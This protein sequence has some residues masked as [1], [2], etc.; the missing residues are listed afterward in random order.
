ML[1]REVLA[2]FLDIDDEGMG[3]RV[4]GNS[5][6]RGRSCV[7]IEGLSTAERLK[8]FS[9][10]S[11]QRHFGQWKHQGYTREEQ[12]NTELLSGKIPWASL[13]DKSGARLQNI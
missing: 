13:E 1:Y 12:R 8:C 5:S 7:G 2:L 10:S 4:V 9:L 11:A 6:P 3:R